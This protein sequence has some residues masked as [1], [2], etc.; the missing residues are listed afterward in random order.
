ML[1]GYFLIIGL[2]MLNFIAT[3]EQI[4]KLK[5]NLEYCQYSTNE[6]I[7]KVP[8]MTN[9]SAEGFEYT[10]LRYCAIIA[11]LN[12][13]SDWFSSVATQPTCQEE[14]NHNTDTA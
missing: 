7:Y 3:M 12:N 11:S 5:K 13:E 6:H 14:Q 9:T 2:V 1:I 4:P 8:K 10:C